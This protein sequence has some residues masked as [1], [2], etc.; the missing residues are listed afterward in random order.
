[1]LHLPTELQFPEVQVWV[2]TAV[3]PEAQ[4]KAQLLPLLVDPKKIVI[5]IS[6]SNNNNN[7]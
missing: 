3:Y 4:V 5:S 1:M 2:P 6:N 7:N